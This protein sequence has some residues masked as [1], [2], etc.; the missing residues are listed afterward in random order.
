MLKAMPLAFQI[1]AGSPMVCR[2]Q[3][4]FQ[5]KTR[6][7]DPSTPEKMSHENLVNSNRVHG[8]YSAEG[9]RMVQKD[10]AGSGSVR[11]GC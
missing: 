11:Q 8:T 3:Q 5:T 1:P 2:F 7:N 6:R 10:L 4:S 9:E